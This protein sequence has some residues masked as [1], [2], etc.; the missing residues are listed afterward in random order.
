MNT[1]TEDAGLRISFPWQPDADPAF[2]RDR[3]WL[4]TNGLG[5]YASGTLLGWATRKYHGLF[6]PNLPSPHGRTVIIPR[7]DE[8]IATQDGGILLGGSLYAGGQ[9]EGHAPLYLKEFRHEWQAPTWVFQIDD[10]IL[11]KTILMPFGQNTV[12]ILYRL[13]GGE[14]LRIK[15]RPFLA[16]RGHDESLPVS[17]YALWSVSF[18]GERFE[19]RIGEDLPVLRLR[20]DPGYRYF[21]SEEKV[22][23][24]HL[25]GIEKRRGLEHH[26]VLGSPGYFVAEIRPGETTAFTT[27]TEPWEALDRD[28]Q[29]VV[30]SEGQRLKK[31]LAR[32]PEAARTGFGAQLV[33]AADEFVVLPASRFEE[34]L[35][36]RAAGEETRSIIAGYHW[37]SD[38]G[39]DTM[40]SLEGLTLCTGRHR[41]ARAILMTFS[42]YIK[43]GLIPNQF[44]EGQREAVYNTVDA[45]FWY[46]HALDRYY[47]TTGDRETLATLFEVL[48]PVIERHVVGTRF[49]IGADPKD[50]LIKA[51]SEGYQLTW[52]DAKVADW[53]VTPRRGKPVE[54]QALWYN[55]LCLMERWAEELG[56]AKND[57]ADLAGKV[58]ESF[59][60]R[61]WYEKGG[62]LSDVID[63]ED[64]ADA[65][66]LRPNQIFAVSLRFPVLQP[67]LWKPVVDVVEEKLLTP[68]GLRTLAPG[69][70]EYR[71]RYEGDRW[72]RDAAYHQGLVWPWLIGHFLDARRR[73]YGHSHDNRDFLRAFEGHLCDAGIGMISEIFD[74][75]P[76]YTPR[77]CI[78]QAWSVA[79]VLRAYMAGAN[80]AKPP[81]M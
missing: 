54:I 39:R 50:G 79:E 37:F 77:G 13:L 19:A 65:A 75:E 40:I 73:V 78:A 21:V 31:L 70:K 68:Y 55:A 23:E 24:T 35:M 67:S 12:Y 41:E 25:Y 74:A 80:D 26:E 29:E 59:N 5:G 60:M 42:H 33:L 72:A 46:F 49:G 18:R 58:H 63:A 28:A 27:S 4:V 34:D 11:E 38:W 57:Y 81:Q 22:S 36:A 2:L 45:T 3:E 32:A 44:P 69:E 14:P 8:K 9:E 16:F 66:R 52:M 47:Q 64:P 71:P 20:I 30:G 51:A 17:S 53:V 7:L 10:R 6:V 56:E 48:K 1:P 76:P 43:D 62:Y 61:F 15:L